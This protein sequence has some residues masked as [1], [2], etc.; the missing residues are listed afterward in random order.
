MAR[1][2]LPPVPRWPFVA[3]GVAV[4]VLVIATVATATTSTAP[5]N[6]ASRRPRAVKT[7]PAPPPPPAVVKVAN[8]TGSTVPWDKPLVVTITGGRLLGVGATQD[9][10]KVIEGSVSTDA[11]RWQ[12]DGT[13]VPLSRLLLFVTYRDGGGQRVTRSFPLSVADS[14]KHLRATISPDADVVGVGMPIIVT[15]TRNVPDAMRAAVEH[16][17]DVITTPHV[18]GAWHWF[19]GDEVHWRPPSYWRAGTKVTVQTDLSRLDM[20]DGVWGADQHT[21]TFTVGAAHV[22]KVDVANHVMRVYNGGQL[23]RAMPISAGRDK[24]PTMGGVHIALEKDQMVIMDSATVGIPRNSPDG[25][26]EKVYWNV[27]ISNGGAFVHAAPWSVAEQ[28]VSNVSHG[29]VNLSPDNATW[30]YNFSLRGDVVD[31]FN[32]PRGPSPWDAGTMDWNMS[33]PQWLA[34]SATG[35]TASPTATG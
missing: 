34:G 29:C 26:Y 27:R 6:P 15:F 16:R 19:S 24:Y 8:V 13:L 35:G 33:W 32:T 9:D 30:F 5:S 4:G 22:S 21:A 18:D 7:L 20:G 17:L 11:A 14:V 23:V 25:Y 28:G 1:R 31:I 3:A 12:S 10:G 2:L